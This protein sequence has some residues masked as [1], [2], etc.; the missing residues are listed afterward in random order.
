METDGNRWLS[1]TTLRCQGYG[2]PFSTSSR[3]TIL[4]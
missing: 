4:F 1:I 3:C 2:R